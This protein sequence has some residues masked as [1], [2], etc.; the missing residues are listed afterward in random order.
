MRTGPDGLSSW[1]SLDSPHLYLTR[2]ARFRH[3]SIQQTRLDLPDIREFLEDE[4][5]LVDGGA[6]I[7]SSDTVTCQ[8]KFQGRSRPS[9]M[10]LRCPFGHDVLPLSEDVQELRRLTP[11]YVPGRPESA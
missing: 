3:R 1:S 2:S 6:F 9:S 8:K 5:W 11:A 7:R 4:R 10:S